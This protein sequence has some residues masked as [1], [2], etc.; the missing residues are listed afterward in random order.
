MAAALPQPRRH[1]RW[2]PGT[3]VLGLAARQ[4]LVPRPA[5][6]ERQAAILRRRARRACRSWRSSS[7]TAHRQ[8]VG[9]DD[10]LAGAARPRRWRTT[11]TTARP[12]TPATRE[13]DR[14][15]STPTAG[16]ACTSSTS[17]RD[18][19]TPYV[20]PPVRR[21][22]ALRRVRV[23]TSPAGG[24]WSTSGRTSSAGCGSRV[25]GDGRRRRS[26]SGTPRCSRTA[27]SAPGRCAPPRRPT[28]SSS[29]GA[30]DVFEPTM[31][32][33]GFRYAEVDGWPGELDRGRRSRRSSCTPTCARTGDVRVLG[34]RC[35]TSCTATSVWGLRGQLPRRADR[36]PAARRAAR[37][38][39]RHRRVRAHR[40]VPLRRRRRSCASWL[41]RPRR[42][43]RST[44]TAGCRSSCPTCLKYRADADGLP[45]DPESTAIW[46]DA[47]VWVPWAL[48]QAYGDRAVL[49]APVRR[50]CVA[51]VRRVA[52]AALGTGL[53]D[54]GL[55]VRRLARPAARR[56]TTPCKAKA[57]T[58]VVATACLYRS[59]APVAAAA[60][61]LGRDDDAAEFAALAERSCAAP[62]RALRRPTTAGC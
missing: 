10:D 27:S 20:G 30:E 52:A 5:R 37:L 9:T 25:Q 29:A 56:R 32:F 54:S 43:S 23:W 3:P 12:S 7:R 15:G 47:A 13:L 48:W 53:W 35:S 31:T 19:L 36:L 42:S 17:T 16:S 57:D 6:L 14:P 51:H 4:R 21:Q 11:S 59:A 24:P 18:R 41:R 26:P 8:V 40:G 2:S 49:R 33:H 38:D 61:I 22:E 28:G 50:R 58:G 44:P 39:R 60:A 34:R 55:P 46:S 45:A 1:R 62:S